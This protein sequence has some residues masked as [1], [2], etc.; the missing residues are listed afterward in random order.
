[1]DGLVLKKVA[2]DFIVYE[3]LALPMTH[4]V[5]ADF[6]YLR[7][8]KCGYTTFEAAEELSLFFGLSRSEVS[9]AGLKDEDAV[10]DQFISLR[11][12]IDASALEQFNREHV[13]SDPKYMHLMH[14]GFGQRKIDIGQLDGNSFRITARNLSPSLAARMR[15]SSGKFNLFFVNYYDTQRFG[16]A[17]GP[18][19][20][21]LIGQAILQKDYGAALTLLRQSG[22]AEGRKALEHAGDPELFFERIDPR[23]PAFYL[24][25]YSSY[26]WNMRLHELLHEACGGQ[27]YEIE[28]E[29]IPF[30]FARPPLLVLRLL[31]ARPHLEYEKYRWVDDRIVE[32]MSQRPT[33]MQTQMILN[34]VEPDD[35]FPERWKCEL[36][37]FLSSGCYATIAIRQLVDWIEL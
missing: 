15:E 3:S 10:T 36:S 20:T 5:Q 9:Y 29:G 34:S 33:V 2:D 25:S 26:R 11:R 32:S 23:L 8:R 13:S 1:M 24:C 17:G 21:H 4:R 35:L 19:Q 30:S 12:S 18:K 16:V 6:Q 37:F 27:V 31:E 28:S 14:C 7:L 22:S